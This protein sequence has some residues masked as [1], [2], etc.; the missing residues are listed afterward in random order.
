M[1]QLSKIVIGAGA[2][3]LTTMVQPDPGRADDRPRRVAETSVRMDSEASRRIEVMRTE[4]IV[5][6]DLFRNRI[7]LAKAKV[8]FGRYALD[9]GGREVTLTLDPGL[10]ATTEEVLRRAR[11]PFA[12]AVVLDMD[13]RI[14]AMAG[15]RNRA[16]AVER[17]FQLPLKV[18][19]PAASVFKIVTS[20]AL[21]DAGVKPKAKV[22]YHG[23]RRSVRKSNLTDNK[24][25]KNCDSLSYALAK[26][27][28]A[29]IAKLTHRHLRPGVLRGYARRFGFTKPPQFALPLAESTCNIPRKPLAFAKVAAGFWK[30]R[31]SPLQGALVAHTVATGGLAVTPRIVARVE[32]ADGSTHLVS[33]P[34]A[35]R[36]L[37]KGTART[38]TKMLVGTTEFGSARKG[39]RDRRGRRYLPGVK[40]AGKT[41][42]LSVR[43][44]QY[45]Q[46]SWFV[47]YAPAH[48]PKV[49][50]AVLLGNPRQWHLKAHTAARMVLQKALQTR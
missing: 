17:D 23:G 4:P 15:R 28:N 24:R 7:D 43:S 48:A 41:G 13:G 2:V 45:V 30:T 22:C 42:T 18:W 16:P 44:P 26:S 46:Y 9:V 37:S 38:L 19:A 50:V 31:L 20:A 12:A 36:V 10:Q 6:D 5:G 40:V 25:D 33:S 39:F 27:Q 1:A 35:R 34:P 3:V 29:I 49:T 11:A 8:R 21:V 14:L 32:D 47:G